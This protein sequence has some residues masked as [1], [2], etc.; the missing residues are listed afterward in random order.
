MPE[1]TLGA[2]TVAY[3]VRRSKRARQASLRIDAQRGLQIVLPQQGPEI[4][5]EKLLRSRE[6]WIL[7]YAPLLEQA[8]STNSRYVSG[9]A[10]PYLGQELRLEVRRD[11]NRGRSTVTLAD[12]R[13]QVN[14]REGI[15]RG[16]QQDETRQALARWYGRQARDYLPARARELAAKY[17]FSFHN[18]AI[19]NQRTRWGSCSSNGNL[20]F[21][22]RLMMA[23]P[24][25]IDYV[26][27]HELCHLREMNHSPRFWA[28]VA[29]FCPDY[30]HWR[31][32]FRANSLY[33]QL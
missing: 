16:K 10:L 33:L 20:N 24:Q 8:A 26:I 25:A 17:G 30:K 32:W 23:P 11:A 7:K 19:R 31:G 15:A 27:I 5:V 28:L 2:Q 3:T 12:G 29:Q 4:D 13:L 6:E 14:L 1:I 22:Q 21:N 9:A 18:V